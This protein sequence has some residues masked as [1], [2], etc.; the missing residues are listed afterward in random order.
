LLDVEKSVFI[1]DPLL[2]L[3]LAVFTLP[4]WRSE[5]A[6][7]RVVA[8]AMMLLAVTCAI[9]ATSYW[10]PGDSSWGPRHHVLPVQLAVLAGAA[11]V[12]EK[13]HKLAR[14]ARILVSGLIL[15][16]V[17]IQ[18]SSVLL[19]YNLEVGQRMLSDSPIIVPIIRV[20]NF[21]AIA[22]GNFIAWGLDFGNQGLHRIAASGIWLLPIRATRYLHMAAAAGLVALWLVLLS[23]VAWL[24][25]DRAR[26]CLAKLP[27][28]P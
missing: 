28:E 15:L 16:A 13:W 24:V 11:A 10:W 6:A 19:D 23:C 25:W 27:K 18:L 22:S 8:A 17:E 3:A 7:R 1:F 21:F 12:F 26:F 20:A 14:P 2:L 9:Y 4:T 5:E